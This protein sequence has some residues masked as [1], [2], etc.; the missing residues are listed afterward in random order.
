MLLLMVMIMTIMQNSLMQVVFFVTVF[1]SLSVRSEDSGG[2]QCR[3]LNESIMVFIFIYFILVK[4]AAKA[5]SPCLI[6]TTRVILN[7]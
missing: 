6:R 7:I 5:T 2:S 3:S 4:D 1:R